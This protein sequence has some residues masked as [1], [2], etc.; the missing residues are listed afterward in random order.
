MIRGLKEQ[1]PH[2]HRFEA[3]QHA[4]RVIGDRIRSYN[5]RNPHQALGKKALAEPFALAANNLIRFCRVI[6]I[7]LCDNRLPTTGMC[8]V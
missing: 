2:R 6:T 7:P 5:H 3:S 8:W 1:C 4:S